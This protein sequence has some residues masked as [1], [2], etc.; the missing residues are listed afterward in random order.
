MTDP[1]PTPDTLCAWCQ[2]RATAVPDE[3]PML[4]EGAWWHRR[5]CYQAARLK[6]AGK[7]SAYFLP[8][9]EVVGR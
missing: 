3:P 4:W 7:V 6:A 9:P 1:R 2:V 5:G 8:W